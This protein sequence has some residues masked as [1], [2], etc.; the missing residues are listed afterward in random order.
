MKGTCVGMSKRCICLLLLLCVLLLT[1]AIAHGEEAASFDFPG[2]F[3]EEGAA[4]VL[5]DT[6]YISANMNIF[7]NGYYSEA[8]ASDITVVECY[9]R[10][11]DCMQ[12]LFADGDW[13]RQSKRVTNFAED[14][15]AVVLLSGDNSSLLKAGLVIGNGTVYRTRANTQR[16]CAVIWK[17]GTMCCYTAEQ[18]TALDIYGM[19]DEIRHAFMFGPSL[20]T[21]EGQPILA[22]RDFS[23]TEVYVKNPRSAIGSDRPG[24]Y[25]LVTVDG[26]GVDSRYEEKHRSHGVTLC[27]L[28]QI[29]YDLGC[30]T[31][32][33]LDGGQSVSL[34]FGGQIINTP[35]KNGRRIGD[36]IALIEPEE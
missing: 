6:H 15:G 19:T 16:D 10:S 33:N 18:L 7:V 11:A 12:R 22:K 21:D 8:Y 36:V 9:I 13:N 20:L 2:L 26:R 3:L 14:S 24:H 35:Y 1:C 28:S 4:P 25:L 30:T 31:A 32:Y 23:T 27:D 5:T 17:D 34:W 29:M